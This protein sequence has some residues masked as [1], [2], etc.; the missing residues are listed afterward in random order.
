MLKFPL[1]FFG[2]LTSA[3]TVSLA[4]PLVASI[5]PT[6]I[7]ET[8][9]KSTVRVNG[10]NP[11]S[12]VI[13]KKEGS[14]YYVLTA[15]HVVETPDEY[16]IITDDEQVHPLDYAKVF[17]VPDTDLAIAEFTSDQDYPPVELGDS[18]NVTEGDAVFIAGWPHAGEAI[19]YIYQFITGNISGLPPRLLPGG[20]GLIYTST[21]RQGMSGGPVFNNDGAVVG[22]HGRAEGKEIYLPESNFDSTTI[23]DGFSLGV[24]INVFLDKTLDP[25]TDSD[26]GPPVTSLEPSVEPEVPP[27]VRESVIERRN[28]SDDRFEQRLVLARDVQ[29]PTHW[30][31]RESEYLFTIDIPADA[32][33]P[34]QQIVF[35]QIEGADYPSFS[36]RDT[37]AFAAGNR[38]ADIPLSLVSNDSDEK[39]MTVVFDP[40][41]EPGRQITVALK[42]HRNP[43]DGTYLFELQAYP[44]GIDSQRQRLGTRTLRFYE[45]DRRSN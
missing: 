1:I 29:V 39:T 33:A 19:P 10:Q 35:N 12:G 45:P 38:S 14:Q 15:K 13:Y 36:I 26:S 41:I 40:P 22:I 11:G 28:A 8:A 43:R 44:P 32:G 17:P 3:L 37:H 27:A 42:A 23:R 18:D 16:E 25:K 4:A 21:A 34:L 2:L 7:N 20:Y 9:K 31:F 6:V 5:E 30:Q 24:P